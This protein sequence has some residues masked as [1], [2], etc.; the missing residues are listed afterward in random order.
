MAFCT[1]CGATVVGRFCSGCGSPAAES[2]QPAY[3]PG[4]P[5]PVAGPPVGVPAARK[6]SPIVWI[7]IIILGFVVLCGLAVVAGGAFFFHKMKTAGVSLD[8]RNGGLS[9][10][11]RDGNVEIGTAGKTP[12]WIPEYP[13]SHPKFAVRALGGRDGLEEGGNFTF[14]TSD[15][16]SRVF[17]FYEEKCKDMGM[18]VDLTS[19]GNEGGIMVAT[20]N[21]TDR[22]S[23][24]VVVGTSSGE[25]TVNVTYGRK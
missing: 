3:T 18:K 5:Q 4:V 20:D 14:T 16:G 2:S 8:S 24:T 19:S 1:T 23:L 13:G 11:S 22:R 25:T 17:S 6:T 15:S 10:T 7:L 9:I 12:A 21:A